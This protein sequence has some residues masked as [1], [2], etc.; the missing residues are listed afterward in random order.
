MTSG[1]L[2]PAEK[3]HSHLYIGD[4]YLTGQLGRMKGVFHIRAFTTCL[5]QDEC[6]NASC[7]YYSQNQ[8]TV[9]PTQHTHTH[10][11]CLRPAWQI[12][13]LC[14][15]KP[16]CSF[17]L[18]SVSLATST[19]CPAFTQQLNADNSIVYLLG[20]WSGIFKRERF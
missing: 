4:V 5:P 18:T 2:G 7:R 12:E 13:N 19:L 14:S 15:Q 9:V 8:T 16:D 17:P 6:L 3:P 11:R 10:T 1:S 20:L